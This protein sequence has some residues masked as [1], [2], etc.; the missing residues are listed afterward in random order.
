MKFGG[1]FFYEPSY[2]FDKEITKWYKNYD[3]HILPFLDII[4][5]PPSL[6][7]SYNNVDQFNVIRNLKLFGS[8]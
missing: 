5:T 4:S 7:F 2:I 6:W 8:S 1:L 3:L